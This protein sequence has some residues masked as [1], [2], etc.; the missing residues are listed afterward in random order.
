MTTTLKTQTSAVGFRRIRGLGCGCA[1][2]ACASCSAESLGWEHIRGPV[3]RIFGFFLLAGSQQ[4]E[5]RVLDAEKAVQASHRGKSLTPPQNDFK[6]AN[7]GLFLFSKTERIDAQAIYNDDGKRD[8]G[9][10]LI[11]SST[12]SPGFRTRA[13]PE[14]PARNLVISRGLDRD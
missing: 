12:P 11:G 3:K 1:R 2:V 13:S 4:I 14:D 9:R 6:L 10:N 7:E 5:D 8:L